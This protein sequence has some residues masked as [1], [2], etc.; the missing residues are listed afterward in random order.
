MNDKP[1]TIP[2]EAER[3]LL[4][5]GHGYSSLFIGG[6]RQRMF[7]LDRED[8]NHVA[9][10]MTVREIAKLAEVKIIDGLDMRVLLRDPEQLGRK[11]RWYESLEEAAKRQDELNEA[12]A[13]RA[14]VKKD[15][16]AA[17]QLEAA[18]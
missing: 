13:L 15:L 2:T 8:D 4:V 16:E 17:S 3:I 14:R 11:A 9:L 18:R 5:A 6:K 1:I 10:S 12:A 7:V